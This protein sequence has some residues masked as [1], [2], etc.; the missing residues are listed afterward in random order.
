MQKD[1]KKSVYVREKKKEKAPQ[2]FPYSIL[3]IYF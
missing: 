1:G 3:L 2:N